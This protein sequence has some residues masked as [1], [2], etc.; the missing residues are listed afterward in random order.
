MSPLDLAVLG[1]AA[2]LTSAL[3]AVAGLGGGIVLLAILVLYLEPL[4]AIPVHGVIQLASN[5]SRTWIQ[6]RHVQR[7]VLAYFA[8]LLVPGCFAGLQVLQ[9]IPAA[10][11]KLAIG[12]FV[13]IATWVP[14]ALT[15][16]VRAERLHPRRR[17]LGIGAA[18]GFVTTTLGASGPFLG[19][20][21]RDLGWPR[22]QVVG[23][24]AACQMLGHL[25][26]LALFG[27][28]GFAFRE[29]ALLL[30]ITTTLVIVGTWVGSQLLERLPERGFA[31]LYK[32]VLTLVGVYLVV[33]NASAVLG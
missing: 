22:Q 4:V 6:R 11:G 7:E 15:L 33:T 13:L 10:V 1:A 17:F 3:T 30:A 9:R 12:V 29:H 16:G 26:K 21:F 27:L 19:P 8:V 14:R 24:F 20:F 5:G 2:F 25:A 18:V 32:T 28:A 31:A 23:T